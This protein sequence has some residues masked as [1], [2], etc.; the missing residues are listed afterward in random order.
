MRYIDSWKYTA[1]IKPEFVPSNM[2]EFEGFEYR[3][4]GNEEN[5]MVE[6]SLNIDPL[7]IMLII[8]E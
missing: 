3:D 4:R 7:E 6:Y 8:E 5:V 2:D 1:D